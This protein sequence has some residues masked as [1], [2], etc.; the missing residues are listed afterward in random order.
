MLVGATA[1]P[2]R[3]D[4][5]YEVRLGDE[6]IRVD[7]IGGQVHAAPDSVPGTTIELTFRGLRALILGANAAEIERIGGIAIKGDRRR[8]RALLNALT[9]PL[10]L[11][12]LR[13]QLQAGRG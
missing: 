5:R 4:G 6:A 13:P 3:A 8:A 7:M 12:G 9:G 10:L 11:I 1:I 2:R